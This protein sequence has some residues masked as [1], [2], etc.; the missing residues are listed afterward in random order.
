MKYRVN[1]KSDGVDVTIQ[2]IEGK[3]KELLDAFQACQEGR[4]SCPTEEYKK[5]E[6]LESE[7]DQ[8][9]ITIHLKSK[10]GMNLDVKEIKKC[11]DYTKEMIGKKE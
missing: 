7:H 2:D 1:E 3:H 4:C 8:R 5:L 9:T 6:S 10:K 11:L